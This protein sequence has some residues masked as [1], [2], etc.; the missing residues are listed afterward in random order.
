[1]SPVVVTGLQECGHKEVMWAWGSGTNQEPRES[2]GTIG[3]ERA[4]R[5]CQCWVSA[6]KRVSMAQ[7]YTAQEGRKS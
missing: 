4:W 6:R 7:V 3:S 5:M 2:Q 1:M